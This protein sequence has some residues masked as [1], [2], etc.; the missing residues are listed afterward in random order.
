MSGLTTGKFT[1]L[2]AEVSD[3]ESVFFKSFINPQIL[4]ITKT[5]TILVAIMRIP[6]FFSS[7]AFVPRY[8]K[9][10]QKKAKNARENARPVRVFIK[11][12]RLKIAFEKLSSAAKTKL[13]RISNNDTTANLIS[14]IKTQN[15]RNFQPFC[16]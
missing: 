14:Y 11:F 6:S 7:S 3:M 1:V 9:R 16:V 12:E 13:G 5:T 10:P 2:S 8:L 4:S 15:G